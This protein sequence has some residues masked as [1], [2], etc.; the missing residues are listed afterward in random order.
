MLRLLKPIAAPAGR[1]EITSR[2]C[3]LS[4]WF[5]KRACVVFFGLL[6]GA[7]QAIAP[8]SLQ[9]SNGQ[10]VDV[11]CDSDS[12]QSYALYLPSSYTPGKPWPTIYFFDPGGRGRRPVEL[13]KDIAEKYGFVLAGS[14]NSRNYSSEQARSVNAIWL[15]THRRYAIDT[16]QTYVSGFSGGARVAGRMA[17][18]C[19]QCEIAGVIANGA[20]YPTNQSHSIDKLLYFFAVG[21]QDFNWSEVMSIR[22]EREDKG[23][24]YRV[25]IFSG[26]HQWA[27][28]EIMEDA[29][30]WMM[31]R[32]MQSRVRPP[33]AAFID[34]LLRKALGDAEGAEK[35]NDALAQ[36]HAYRSLASDFS[37][38][39]DVTEAEKKLAVVKKS[40][41]LKTARKKEQEQIDDESSLEREVSPKLH[42]Y[43]SGNGED[44][45]AL[46][47]A[48]TQGMLRIN[49]QAQHSKNESKRL[50]AKRA[51]DALWV[52]GIESGEEELE[53]RHFAMA[54][55]C[56]DLM[57]QVS[58]NPWPVLLLA[59]TY[60]AEG[61]KKQAIR[62][63]KEA[64]RRGLK[65]ADA[66]ESDARFQVFKADPEFQSIVQALK[67]K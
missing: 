62:E 26:P 1:Q 14:N 2:A 12:Q 8:P 17:L 33:D 50:V 10:I 52:S 6:P 55:A 31:L 53:A 49:D 3:R 27:P 44:E 54:A 45:V 56:F 57:R 39:R 13:Y 9:P 47:N 4:I 61:N 32:A 7:G 11:T 34:R 36:F 48:I 28:P 41:A 5:A 18:S 65:D 30:E 46:S 20:G 21:N 16:R 59:E 43:I 58:A 38:L 24:P 22:R 63:L 60:A 25:R 67:Q 42:T 15:D 40:P 64:V 35:E 37:G 23:L 19:P 51:F 66:I 29:V